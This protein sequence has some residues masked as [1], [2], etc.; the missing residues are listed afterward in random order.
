MVAEAG[1]GDQGEPLAVSADDDACERLAEAQLVERA[2][3]AIDALPER[4][5]ALMRRHYLDG[6]R[7]DQIAI[8]LGLS[9][10]WASRLHARALAKLSEALADF[11]R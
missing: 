10:S 1:F 3:A 6:E 4:E 8:D 9:K 7:L 11:T 2:M 5:A